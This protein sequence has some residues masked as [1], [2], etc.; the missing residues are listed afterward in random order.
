M[1]QDGQRDLDGR[2][3]FKGA[4]AGEQL[5]PVIMEEGEG[6]GGSSEGAL[7]L[8]HGARARGQGWWPHSTMAY[9]K[10]SAD[11]V[12]RWLASTSG[13]TGGEEE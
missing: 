3:I 10:T 9:E 7:R 8:W 6:G 12:Y 11:S 5:P 1:V 2:Q 4:L 13:A